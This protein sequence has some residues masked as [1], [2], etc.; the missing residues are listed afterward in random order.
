MKPKKL[1]KQTLFYS[2]LGRTLPNHNEMHELR[3]EMITGS[4][5]LWSVCPFP[6]RLFR[7]ND[8]LRSALVIC[9]FLAHE[10]FATLYNSGIQLYLKAVVLL[11]FVMFIALIWGLADFSYWVTSCEC[12]IFVLRTVKQDSCNCD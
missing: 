10:V 12:G 6:S 9:I 11:F 8:H 5:Q 1:K 4:A 3:K 2:N 7:N